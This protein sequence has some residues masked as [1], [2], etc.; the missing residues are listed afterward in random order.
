MDRIIAY[1]GVTTMLFIRRRK[2]TLQQSKQSNSD[3]HRWL[4]YAQSQYWNKMASSSADQSDFRN[5]S[6]TGLDTNEF[7]KL[8]IKTVHKR[9]RVS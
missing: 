1:S 7:A 2:A 8:C 6:T 3:K 4:S 9:L 5:Q